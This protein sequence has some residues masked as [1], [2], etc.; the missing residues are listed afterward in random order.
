MEVYE[1]NVERNYYQNELGSPLRIEDSAGTIKGSY[2]IR[3]VYAVMNQMTESIDGKGNVT[4][5]TYDI[6]GNV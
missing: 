6:M 1:E 2:V 5:Y 3:Y 4:C